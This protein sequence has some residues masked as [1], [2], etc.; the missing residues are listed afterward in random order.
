MYGAW[1]AVLATI[2]SI[3]NADGVLLRALGAVQKN[4]YG[5]TAADIMAGTSGNDTFF[6]NNGADILFGG[7]GDDIYQVYDKNAVVK[8]LAGDGVDLIR[9]AVSYTLPDNVEDL[10][11]SLAKITGTGNALDNQIVGSDGE[12]TLIGKGGN[13]VL[14]GGAGADFFVFGKGDGRDLITDFENGI[15]KVRLTDFGITNFSTVRSMMTQQGSNVALTFGSGEK[16]VFANH[17]LADFTA[18]D[19]QLSISTANR[20]MTF[21]DEFNTLSLQSNGGTWRTTFDYGGINTRT[22][23]SNGE[24]QI[25]MD[26]AFAGTG[27]T[28]LGVNPFSISNG[29]LDITAAKASADV[30][31]KIWGYDYTSGLLTT[32]GTFSQLYGYFEVSAK[33]PAGQGLW[34]AFW[35]LPADGS[36]PPEI[37]IFEQ[38]GKDPNTVYMS[39]LSK[40]GGVKAGSQSVL[41]V[42]NATTQFHTYGV[43]WAPD[44]LTY[45]IDGVEVAKRPTPADYNKPM[46]MLLNV[47]VGGG[48]AGNPDPTQAFGGKMGVDY[49]HVYSLENSPVATPPVVTTP[50]VTTPVVTAPVVTA[51][52]VTAPVVTA[53]V[54]TTPA[55]TAPA[56]AALPQPVTAGKVVTAY[57]S[58]VLPVNIETLILAGTAAADGTGNALNNTMTG[59]IA[60]NTLNGGAGNDYLDGNGGGDTL[61]GGI[62]NDTYVVE[63]SRDIIVEKAGEGTDTVKS[64]I[65]WTLGAEIEN[66]TLTGNAAVNGYGNA[67]ANSIFGNGAANR[68][69]GGAGNDYLNGGG[70]GDT[71]V[72]GTGNDSYQ[73]TDARDV[74]IENANEGTDSVTSTV[75]YHLSANVENL[76]LIGTANIAGYGNDLANSITGNS[77]S[78]HLEG[79]AGNDFLNGDLGADTLIGGTGNDTYVVDNVGDI[80]IE[81]VNEGTDQVNASITYSLGD[82]VENLTLTGTAAINGTGNALNNSIAGNDAANVLNGGAG[83][84]F[85][86]GGGG[87][88]TIV[89]G[90]GNDTLMGGSGADTFVFGLGFGKDVISD[91]SLADGDKLDLK[92]LASV[93]HSVAHFSGN[94][95]ITM[96]GGA[97]T[98]TLTGVNL[99]DAQI[100]G[101]FH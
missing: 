83:N 44:F 78:N 76:N 32:K 82:N 56:P 65:T 19:F 86:K 2:T 54:V 10:S 37:D 42:Q 39:N 28:A 61:I 41:E 48:W 69:E 95:V 13:D 12:Q 93:S 9:S 14:T 89:G 46:Y 50:V 60:H 40:A 80:V 49:V 57:T 92:A 59:N 34:P 24:K 97:D 47:A 43:N 8:E 66:L 71:L 81:Y 63:D 11:L 51:S 99:T 38:L 18:N 1:E 96:A 58:F 22:L 67:L 7:A 33:L 55:V 91:F 90:A 79:G 68:L 52:V 100:N 27:T 17:K 87:N 73:V 72:G 23:T 88:D 53:P 94:T 75:T 70:G 16:I 45:Y 5:T 20:T 4:F 3:I 62:G 36:W 26:A 84:D 64:A 85:I 77:G 15:D 21:D 35:L 25:Y 74:V 31:A 29:V 98:I 6:G 101:F 30:A